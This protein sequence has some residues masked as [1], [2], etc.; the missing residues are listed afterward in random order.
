MIF[1]SEDQN[2]SWAGLQNGKEL[3]TAVFAYTLAYTD[4]LG[5]Q[6]TMSGNVTLIK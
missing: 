5:I 4:D 3:N 6:Q 1:E 2:I